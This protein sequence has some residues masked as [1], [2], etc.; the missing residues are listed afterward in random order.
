MY[1]LY[2]S[3]MLAFWNVQREDD[4][5]VSSSRCTHQSV[6]AFIVRSNATFVTLHIQLSST[7]CFG[8][9]GHHQVDC[10]TY[11]EKNTKMDPPP[12]PF[13]I[14]QCINCKGGGVHLGILFYVCRHVCKV[15][16]GQN[17]QQMTL[18]SVVL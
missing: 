16:T 12:T 18:E 9:F 17:M 10:K 13:T 15:K 7:I 1:Y 6:S 8:R 2:T 5:P 3:C 4:I 11:M 14:F